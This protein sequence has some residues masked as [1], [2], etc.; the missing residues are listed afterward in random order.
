MVKCWGITNRTP[1]QRGV[2]PNH[3]IIG[4]C[5]PMVLGHTVVLP[6]KI[7]RLY[8][9]QLASMDLHHGSHSVTSSSTTGLEFGP[10]RVSAP[11]LWLQPEL[12]SIHFIMVV[13][14][15]DWTIT[16]LSTYTSTLIPKKI[17]HP[18]PPKPESNLAYFFNT[19]EI[20]QTLLRSPT[21]AASSSCDHGHGNPT[22]KFLLW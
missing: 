3:L 22:M 13:S 18:H 5:T 10:T 6:L 19:T 15:Q 11:L 16:F 2:N 21:A 14:L 4:W 20:A 17:S 9:L 1:N 7:W 8:G 12:S